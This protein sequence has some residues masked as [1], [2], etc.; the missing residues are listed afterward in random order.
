MTAEKTRLHHLFRKAEIP[1]L[2]WCDSCPFCFDN[3]QRAHREVYSL[4]SPWSKAHISSKM[5]NSIAN[6][7][8]LYQRHR[9]VFSDGLL[10]HRMCLAVLVD[11]TVNHQLDA[12]HPAVVRRRIAA[13]AHKK[14]RPLL[15][16]VTLVQD[17]PHMK[18][19]TTVR[20]HHW[21]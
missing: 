3:M 14:T 15:F 10:N 20:V 8:S 12:R 18:A 19:L 17:T 5:R 21:L 1:C 2:T 13:P 6:L 16:H 9:R 4:S 11:E 7:Q